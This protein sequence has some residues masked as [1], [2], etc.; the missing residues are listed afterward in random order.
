L[1]CSL[2]FWRAEHG[3]RTSPQTAQSPAG[4]AARATQTPLAAPETIVSPQEAKELFRSVDEILQ[5][6]SKD[7]GLPSTTR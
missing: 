2:Q 1:A 5:F 6:V 4:D 3:L 7:T